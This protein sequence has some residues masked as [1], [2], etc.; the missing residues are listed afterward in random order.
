ML[1]TQEKMNDFFEKFL[2]GNTAR[3]GGRK[4]ERKG[5]KGRKPS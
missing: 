1:T 3:E 5:E 2:L 4:E